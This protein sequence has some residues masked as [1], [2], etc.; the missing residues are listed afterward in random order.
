MRRGEVLNTRL[1][2]LMAALTTLSQ[3]SMELAL[4]LNLHSVGVSL[5]LIG[6]AVAAMGAGQIVSRLPAGHWYRARQ[7]TGLNSIFLALFGLTTMGLAITASWPLQAALAGLH[8]AAFGLVT[9]FQLALLIDNRQREGSMAST[10]AWYTAA[11]SIGYAGGSPLGAAAIEHLGFGAAF[12]ISGAVAIGA[13]ATGLLASPPS[14][15]AQAEAASFGGVGGLLT[16]LRALPPQIWLAALLVL[17][18]NFMSDSV[19]SFF[20]IYAIALGIPL[21][22]VG[23]LRSLN[24]LVATAVRFGAAAIFRIAPPAAVNHVCIFVMAAATVVLSA[25]SAPVALVLAFLGLGASRGLIRVTSATSV[26]DER[27][28]LGNRVGLASGVY[29]SG[30]DAGTMLAPYVTGL[31]A[32]VAGIPSAFRTVGLGLPVLYYA[33]W[34]LVRSRRPAAASTDTFSAPR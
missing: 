15:H 5:P 21:G 26:A 18:I 33:I 1:L 14:G 8:G 17:Y 34:V 4:P 25:M 3:G 22:F 27:A 7:A 30:L 11:I 13:A 24:S 28:T 16:A 10:M 6:A 32:S 9:T 2:Y 23:L 19:S 20:P 29:N 31:L 12:W